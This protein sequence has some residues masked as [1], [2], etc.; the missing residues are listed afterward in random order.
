MQYK[1]IKGIREGS[2]LL[3]RIAQK[4]LYTFKVQRNGIREY[5]CYQTILSKPNKRNGDDSVCRN[6]CTARVRML[7]NDKCEPMGVQHSKHNDHTNIVDDMTMRNNMKTKCQLLKKEF[8]EDAH[9]MPT[10]HIF[11]REIAK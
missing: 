4:L 5:I 2:L 6:N 3:Y 8:G 1:W 11:Q 9:R 10:R 7:P